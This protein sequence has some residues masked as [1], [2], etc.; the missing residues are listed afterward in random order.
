MLNIKKILK[1][2]FGSIIIIL[3]FPAIIL[4]AVIG[5]CLNWIGKHS[6]K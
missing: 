6:K 4:I 3:L 1:I 5:W 2:I